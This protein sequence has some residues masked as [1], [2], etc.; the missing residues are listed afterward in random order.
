MYI[1]RMCVCWYIC[2][3]LVNQEVD[4]QRQR[5]MGWHGDVKMGWH[6]DVAGLSAPSVL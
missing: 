5:E 2:A 1:N 3:D 6:G 4:R